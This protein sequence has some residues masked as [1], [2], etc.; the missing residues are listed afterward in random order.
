MHGLVQLGDQM[1]LAPGDLPERGEF[2]HQRQNRRA[3]RGRKGG[4]IQGGGGLHGHNLP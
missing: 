4:N 1:L 3:L 2:L